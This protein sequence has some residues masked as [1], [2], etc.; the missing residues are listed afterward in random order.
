MPRF[1]GKSLAGNDLKNFPKFYF[2]IARAALGES[3]ATPTECLTASLWP[4]ELAHAY[5][6]TLTNAS[7][8]GGC[9]G[10]HQQQKTAPGS[11]LERPSWGGS[12]H[13]PNPNV[14][15]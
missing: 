3:L 5:Q 15:R 4:S 11:G 12:A 7:A 14:V 8:G 10:H 1:D 13:D 9:Q 2:G 6:L